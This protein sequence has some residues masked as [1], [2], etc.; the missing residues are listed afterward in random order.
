MLSTDEIKRIIDKD[1]LS[2]KKQYARIGQR[3]YDAEHDILKY[4][5]FYYNADGKLVEDKTRSNI[6]ISHP[7]F[8][9][10][11]D[12][13]S[14]YLLSFKDNPIQA[15]DNVEGLQDY[16][17]E[18]FDEEFWFEIS[19]LVS[20]TY[21]KGFEY[22]YAFKNEDERLTFQCADSLGVIEVRKEDTD[23]K[24]N[25]V[26][27]HYVER[28]DKDDEEI[29][30]IQVWSETETHYYIQERD[31]G[32]IKKDK[33]IEVNPR[34]HVVYTDEKTGKRMGYPLGY[35][36]FWRLDNNRKQY[37]G[38]KPVKE[39]IDD[40]DLHACSLSN[41]LKDFDTPLH[42]VKG[43]NGDN[44]DELQTNLK[45]KKIV[46]VDEHGGID[47]KT[48]DIPYQARVTKLELDEK[49]IYRF[50][51]GLNTFG[52]K[53]TNA[54]TNIAIKAAY[55]LLELKANKMEMRLKSLL[56]KLLKIVLAEINEKNGTDFQ[57]SQISFNFERNL[58]TNE[59]ENI[60]NEMSLAQIKQVEV[61]TLLNLQGLVDDETILR[62]VCEVLD[63]DFDDLELPEEEEPIE[64]IQAEL[65]AVPTEEDV[66]D[67]EGAESGGIS[68]EEKATQDSVIAML[69]EL[70]EGVDA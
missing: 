42:V 8:T 2:K 3:Y 34:P 66:E 38:L 12:Q 57:L 26:I 11:S 44:L 65:D 1:K 6:K 36:P 21:N 30:K 27:Y 20:G 45:T 35:I 18:Y 13:L 55:S 59:T 63:I 46:G 10:L 51:C 52:L 25:Y 24:C 53:D 5:L 16:L 4:R 40:Y 15:D 41:N 69:E 28:I 64:N 32:E 23:D 54:T 58:M 22:L 14:S 31:T 19:E 37:S 47:V 70:L 50:A 62:Q 49:N 9:E 43:F 56:K 39:L 7:F 17:D 48:V 29:I 61:N 60:T 67:V 33:S 68:D